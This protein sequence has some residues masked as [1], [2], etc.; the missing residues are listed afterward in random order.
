MT[1][2]SSIS[3][4]SFVVVCHERIVIRR[5]RPTARVEI[6]RARGRMEP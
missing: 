3:E 1:P 2:V 4:S 6:S 5:L